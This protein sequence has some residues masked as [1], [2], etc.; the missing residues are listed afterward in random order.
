M[1]LNRFFRA[2]PNCNKFFYD[3][4]K[5]KNHECGKEMPEEL[6]QYMAENHPVISEKEDVPARVAEPISDYNKHSEQMG[7]RGQKKE[8]LKV[9][10]E[11]GID[12]AGL[13]TFTAVEEVYNKHFKEGAK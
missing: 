5:F 12:T 3:E 9:L 7:K 11:H 2:C 13:L 4:Q 1:S 6:K 10:K 8:M